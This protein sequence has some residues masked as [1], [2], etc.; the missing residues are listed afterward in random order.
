MFT[1]PEAHLPI[2]RT[3][4]PL[5]STDVHGCAVLSYGQCSAEFYDYEGRH[6]R[7]YSSIPKPKISF[8]NTNFK[9]F[10]S[11]AFELYSGRSTLLK[12]VCA[13]GSLQLLVGS[14]AMV[15]GQFFPG[16][17]WRALKPPIGTMLVPVAN[18][19]SFCLSSFGRL[20]SASHHHLTILDE[21]L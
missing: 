16:T 18:C 8:S 6:V 3:V 7:T 19:S 17:D 4:R 1:C 15:K 10:I 12:Q 2:P 11:S 13:R 9:F 20:A 14:T 21:S 5:M